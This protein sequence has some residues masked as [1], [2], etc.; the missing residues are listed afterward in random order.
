MTDVIAPATAGGGQAAP[1]QAKQQ[2][3]T[4]APGGNAKPAG[5]SSTPSLEDAIVAEKKKAEHH[6]QKYE[7]D[8]P[9]LKD[10]VARL[11]AKLEGLAAGVSL[12]GQPAARAAAK[13]FA[14]LDDSG[15]DEVI[16]K[17]IEDSN[18]GFISEAA[19][20]FARRAAAKAKSEAVVEARAEVSS[21]LE[22]QRV[23]ARI[24][25]E[26]GQD[27]LNAD[28]DLRQN[29]DARVA[30]LAR[31]DPEWFKKDP[32]R[33]FDIFARV[34][35]E[36]RASERGDLERLRKQEGERLAREEFERSSQ[37]I[38]TKARDDVADLLAKGDKQSRREALAKR[39]PWI[40][41]P[42]K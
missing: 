24:S 8:V 23:Y 42:S 7:R 5:S 3:G 32:D 37:T 31:R 13:T 29:A 14:D 36:L 11:S 12:N 21:V 22:Q 26:F 38:A 15:L 17:G 34:D 16:K 40:A 25:S 41:R 35:R 4:A 18:A 27:A 1:A 6:R 33:L 28:S 20:E 19:R 2:S 9:A 10:E 39:L 30:E